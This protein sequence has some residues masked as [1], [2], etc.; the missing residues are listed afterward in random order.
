MMKENFSSHVQKQCPSVF[1][2]HWEFLS[3]QEVRIFSPKLKSH[4]NYKFYKHENK[5][6]KGLQ[7]SS[8]K[9]PSNVWYASLLRQENTVHITTNTPA[10]THNEITLFS[11]LSV[12]LKVPITEEIKKVT[13]KTTLARADTLNEGISMLSLLLQGVT[14]CSPA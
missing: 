7:S 13:F 8:F 4:L 6:S 2:K 10:Y 14:G 5:P 9:F 12:L 11:V 3:K 1:H